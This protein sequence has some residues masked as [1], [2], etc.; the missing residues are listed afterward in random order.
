[1]ININITVLFSIF[2][3]HRNV[4]TKRTVPRLKIKNKDVFK[5]SA[6]QDTPEIKGMIAIED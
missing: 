3:E 1:M 5:I 4:Y 6:L 2:G